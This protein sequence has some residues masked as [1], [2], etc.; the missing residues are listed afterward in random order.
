MLVGSI[1]LAF[2]GTYLLSYFAQRKTLAEA[3]K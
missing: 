1:I 2:L 3:W